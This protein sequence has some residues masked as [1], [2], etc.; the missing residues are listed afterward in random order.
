MIMLFQ[1]FSDYIIITYRPLGDLPMMRII[2]CT[3]RETFSK[4]HGH[5]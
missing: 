3:C 2:L 4:Q 5:V 1:Q